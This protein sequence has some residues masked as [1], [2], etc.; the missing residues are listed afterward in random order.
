MYRQRIILYKE[1]EAKLQS[2]AKISLISQE[3]GEFSFSVKEHT[4]RIT[5][6]LG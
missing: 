4:Y 5:E 1:L 3:K 6:P 2:T